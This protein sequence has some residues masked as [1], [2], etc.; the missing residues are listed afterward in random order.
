MDVDITEEG[1]A[2]IECLLV[3]EHDTD[4]VVFKPIN[5]SLVMLLIYRKYMELHISV[6][7]SVK[8]ELSAPNKLNNNKKEL[9]LEGEV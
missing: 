5:L 4:E 8:I 9:E 6:L 3:E 2:V 1:E 7:Y